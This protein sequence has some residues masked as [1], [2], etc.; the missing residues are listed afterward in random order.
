[1]AH[2]PT[3]VHQL[4]LSWMGAF[5][6]VT[7]PALDWAAWLISTSSWLG[8]VWFALAFVL[9]RRG[10]KML[11]AQ[12]VLSMLIGALFAEACKFSL[13]RVRPTELLPQYVHLPLPNLP[14]THWSFPSG[15]AVLACSAAF[16]AL[17]ASHKGWAWWLVAAALIV[18]WA[19]IYQGVHWPSDVVAGLVIGIV[20]AVIAC[21]LTPVLVLKS[22]HRQRKQSLRS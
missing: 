8:L 3:F 21:V 12:I 17:F 2:I 16:A 15:H 4:D 18:G 20:S 9:W 22:Q 5:H 1:M 6:A 7:N 19:R 13:H 11:A 10:Q 14:D